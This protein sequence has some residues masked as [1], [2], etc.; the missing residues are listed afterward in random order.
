MA[1]WLE[2]ASVVEMGLARNGVG[3]W[4]FAPGVTGFPG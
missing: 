2:G 4:D 3:N 1:H